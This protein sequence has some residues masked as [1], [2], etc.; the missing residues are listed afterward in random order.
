M[1]III[2]GVEPQFKV[3]KMT[4]SVESKFYVGKKISQR[5]NEWS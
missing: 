5:E 1:N 4:E 2:N 3:Y